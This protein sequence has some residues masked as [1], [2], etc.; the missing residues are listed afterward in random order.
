MHDLDTPVLWT[1][2]LA[3]GLVLFAIRTLLRST[4]RV[5]EGHVAVLR[6][7][8]AVQRHDGALRTYGP[9]LHLRWPWQRTTVVAVMEQN[10]DLSGKEGGRTAMADDGTVLRFDSILRYAPLPSSL[11]T[12][13][14]GLRKPLEHITWRFTCLLRNEIAN[15][16]AAQAEQ[17]DPLDFSTEASSYAL[18]R[19]ERKR[20]HAVLEREV[21]QQIGERY[22]VHFRAVDL[23]D[24]L[25]PDELADA[26]NAVMQARAECET[27]LFRAQGDCHQRLL[28]A[29]RG[30]DIARSRAIAAATEIDRIG[31]HLAE[32][33]RAGTLDPYVSRRRAEILSEART[34]YFKEQGR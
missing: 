21:A 16:R 19:R 17:T 18:I 29:E 28:S 9:G 12:F 1:L 13:L 24:V 10:L 34:V 26:L 3:A 5:E 31:K 7:F 4:F 2:G 23:T 30:I 8:G 33:D 20:L 32:L 11:Y 25:P 22:G 27:Y 14:F 6:S 15:F